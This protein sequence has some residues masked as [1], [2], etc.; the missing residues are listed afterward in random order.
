MRNIAK[1]VCQTNFTFVPDVDM[2]PN[3][4]ANL[5][6]PF[7]S[8]SLMQP[9]NKPECSP[10]ARSFSLVLNVLAQELSLKT[11]PYTLL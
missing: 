6:L 1:S 8:R 9:R 10:L 4:G 11:M 7:Y 3:P 2:I 5:I